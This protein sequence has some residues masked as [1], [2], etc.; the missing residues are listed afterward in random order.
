MRS[1]WQCFPLLH[2]YYLLRFD[3][4][5]ELLST[6]FSALYSLT[7]LNLSGVTSV[8]I[9]ELAKGLPS[10]HIVTLYI[11]YSDFRSHETTTALFNAVAL[12]NV[13]DLYLPLNEW[14]SDGSEHARAISDAIK[15]L[16]LKINTLSL[17]K[18]PFGVVDLLVLLSACVSSSL[19]YLNISGSTCVAMIG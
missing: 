19:T 12:S 14:G 2:Q 17:R 4:P 16:N 7:Y 8:G 9:T 1:D 3:G 13:K 11:Y 18:N 10:S 15:L 6:R 5:F